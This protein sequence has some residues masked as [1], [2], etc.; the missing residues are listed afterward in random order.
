MLFSNLGCRQD[1]VVERWNGNV[2][3]GNS[4]EDLA[5]GILRLNLSE[6]PSEII[7]LT[8]QLADKSTLTALQTNVTN[9]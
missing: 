4:L 9:K 6:E 2:L 7:E 3:S 1:E 5:D 8:L